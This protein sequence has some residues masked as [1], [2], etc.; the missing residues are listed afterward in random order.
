MIFRDNTYTMKRISLLVVAI[1]VSLSVFA[2]ISGTSARAVDSEQGQ[3]KPGDTSI[4]N[5]VRMDCLA[6]KFKL[7]KIHEEDGL[8]RVTLGQTYETTSSKLMARFNAR[9]VENRLDG[10]ELI[11]L[12]ADYEDALDTFRDNYQ[13][14]EI[15][16]NS[17]LKADCQSQR[18]TYY[19]SIDSTRQLRNQV[20][21]DVQ[22]LNKILGEYY[23]AFGEFR[24]SIEGDQEQESNDEA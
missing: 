2:G 4:Y 7:S 12:A 19:L 17:L 10:A 22:N 13:K 21:V 18:Q 16:M 15:E 6:V 9:I 1:V 11:R 23:D 5:L 24:A 3:L 14:Y 20:N 8:L